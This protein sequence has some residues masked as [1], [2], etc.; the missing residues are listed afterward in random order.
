MGPEGLAGGPIGKLRED[1]TIEIMI[2]TVKLIGSVNLVGHDGKTFARL[3]RPG[4]L[5]GGVER[6]QIGLFGDL[7]DR[8]S[9]LADLVSG[10]AEFVHLG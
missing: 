9:D 5:D 2:D 8:L 1:D 3:T 4:C 7:G 10:L 6:K